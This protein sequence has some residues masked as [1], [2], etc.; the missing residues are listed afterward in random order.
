VRPDPLRGVA[1]RAVIA[2][3]VGLALFA[4]GAEATLAAAQPAPTAPTFGPA[5]TGEGLGE[6]GVTSPPEMEVPGGRRADG[7][8]IVNGPQRTGR[9]EPPLSQR[10]IDT[11]IWVWLVAALVGG[12][13]WWVWSGR[14]RPAAGAPA[15]PAPDDPATRAP[16]D[17]T[18]A[19]PSATGGGVT[20]P[21]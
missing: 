18:G 1:R 5:G 2:V 6:P 7:S 19:A 11:L 15:P 9:P 8:I 17:P 14:A 20:E 10:I 16:D 3:A 13:T 4:V 21:N 12:T